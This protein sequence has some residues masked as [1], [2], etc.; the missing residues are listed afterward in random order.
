M[1]YIKILFF[2]I[3]SLYFYYLKINIL[4]LLKL[5]IIIKCLF[6]LLGLLDISSIYINSIYFIIYISFFYNIYKNIKSNARGEKIKN[7]KYISNIILKFIYL[8]LFWNL[9]SKIDL[10]F[11]VYAILEYF[12]IVIL[13]AVCL[14]KFDSLIK[15]KLY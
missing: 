9:L 7:I 15:T 4:K 11:A 13:Q 10:I 2:I 1:N 5:T 14:P 3:I 12:N 6:F 8:Y